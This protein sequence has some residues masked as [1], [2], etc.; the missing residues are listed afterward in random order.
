MRRPRHDEGDHCEKKDGGCQN[1][2]ILS[3]EYSREGSKVDGSS[4]SE[5]VLGIWVYDIPD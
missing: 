4:P 1:S 3:M 5:A 2:T